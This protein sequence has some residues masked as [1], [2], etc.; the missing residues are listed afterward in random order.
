VIPRALILP[1]SVLA[2]A[3]AG[4]AG[5][6]TTSAPSTSPATQPTPIRYGEGRRIAVLANRRINESSGV[7]VG[8]LNAGVFWTH[9]DSGGGAYLYAFNAKGENLATCRVTGAGNRDWED[10]ASARIGTRAM[11]IIGDFGDNARRRKYASL[12]LVREP[13]LDATKRNATLAAKAEMEI[14]YRYAGGPADCEAVAYCPVTRQV[15]LATKRTLG[16]DVYALALPAKAPAQT[17]VL[18]PIARLPLPAVTG[19]DISPDGQRAI[20]LTYGPAYQ[21]VRRKGETWAKALAR[22]PRVVPLPRRRQGEAICY[23]PDGRTLYLTSEKLPTPLI[24]V[25]IGVRSL[26]FNF[27]SPGARIPRNRTGGN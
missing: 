23:G 27:R 3:A 5:T 20:V 1:A 9:N 4:G 17:L 15:L 8:R 19:M 13:E 16:S 26:N 24:E 14:R 12:I 2:V 21:V 7:A 25:S 10:I 11:L 22:P 18:K 6:A